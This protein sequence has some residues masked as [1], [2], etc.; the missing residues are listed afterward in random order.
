MIDLHAHTTSS[1]GTLSPSEL[2]REAA[3]A[4]LSAIA[5]TDHDTVDGLDRSIEEGHRVGVRV[6]P[7]I[8]IN[9]RARY[10]SIHLLGYFI[11]HHGAELQSR[12]EQ[13][14]H[15][16]SN[17]NTRIA[18]KLRELG[19]DIDYEEVR[20]EAGHAAVG[21]PH[22]ARVLVAKGAAS[23]FQE[24]FQRYLREGAPAYVER[25]QLS[26]AEGIGLIHSAGGLAVLAHPY[27]FR[28]RPPE[29]EAAIIDLREHGLDG[30][31]TYYSEHNEEF[32]QF[33][34]EVA[35]RH[36]LPVTGGSDFH[37]A[38]KPHIALGVGKGNL[39]IPDSLLQ[40]LQDRLIG[41]GR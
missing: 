5:V 6:I 34:L 17:R 20:K 9:A 18:A 3:R 13:L 10:G 31:E 12:L 25:E 40:P 2:I 27:R 14:R 16:R 29:I 30:V 1:D 36:G 32:T 21:R 38:N 33:L 19:F 11:D 39:N 23:N 26:D 22:F 4:G 15:H 8:E 7:G 37:G 24:V 28:L 35:R 41:R